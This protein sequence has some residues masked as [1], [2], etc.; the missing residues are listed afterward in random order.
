MYADKKENIVL[1][2]IKTGHVF[3]EYA[4]IPFTMESVV[5]QTKLDKK[6][7]NNYEK[8]KEWWNIEK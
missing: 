5:V 3:S 2:D 4:L 8:L 7:I 6:V 1:M